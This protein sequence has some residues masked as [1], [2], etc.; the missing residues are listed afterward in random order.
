MAIPK[1][2]DVTA[3]IISSEFFRKFF[4]LIPNKTNAK[5]TRLENIKNN[6]SENSDGLFRIYR[7]QKRNM[8]TLNPEKAKLNTQSKSGPS[9]DK[10]PLGP[11]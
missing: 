2:S 1:V 10:R 5:E 4:E 3:K 7:A 9:L 6:L 11:F 8:A